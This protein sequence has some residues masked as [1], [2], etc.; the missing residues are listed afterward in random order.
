MSVDN[1]TKHFDG[2]S[3][4]PTPVGLRVPNTVSRSPS[5]GDRS[6]L[7]VI[8][9]S[10]KPILDAELNLGQDIQWMQGHLS[11]RWQSPSGWLGRNNKKDAYFDWI[12][13]QAPDGVTDNSDDTGWDF[14]LEVEDRIHADGTLLDAVVLPKLEALVAGHHVVVEYTNTA[15]PGYN[16]V[17]LDPAKVYDGTNASVKRTDFVFLEVWK[18]LVAPSPLATGYVQVVSVDD[19]TVGDT[20][21]IDGTS[22][23]AVA[24]APGVDEFE[25]GATEEETASNIEA[26]LNDAANSFEGL[27][28]ARA[29][30]N[31]VFLTSAVAGSDGNAVTLALTVSILGCMAVSGATL[32]GGDDRPNKPVTDQSKLFRHGNTLSPSETWLDDQLLD[33]VLATESTQRIQLQYRI[34]ST[35]DSEA[36]NF[37]SNPDGF[38][39]LVSGG[40][41]DEPA[42]FAQG[43][44]DQPVWSGN[45]TDSVSYPFVPAD[46]ESTWLESSAEAFGWLD[47]GLWVAGDGSS[48]A[49]SALG[50]IDGFVYAIPIAFVHRHNN[51]S[52][53]TAS[54]KGFDPASNTN[55][56]P[57]YDHAG[58]TSNLG[59][60]VPA[61]I[62][63]RPD[64]HFCNVIHEDNL[65]DLRRH[66]SLTSVDLASELQTQMQSLLDGNFRTWSVDMA[67]KQTLGGDSG[68]VSTRYL[69]CN[70]IG[71]SEAQGGSSPVSGENTD[72]GVLVR[73]YD[74]VARRF[75]AQPVVERVVVGFWPGDRDGAPVSPG[76]NN[77]GKYVD[78][79]GSSTDTWYEGDTLHLD[80]SELNVTTL[81]GVFDS[82][83]GAGDGG[84][85]SGVGLP[86]STFTAFC[87]EG[88]VITDV[89]N[90]WHDDG[91]YD[92]ATDQEVKFGVI[93]GLGT[94]HLELTLDANDTA[95]TEGQPIGGGNV[96]HKMVG[97][98]VLTDPED[99]G[100]PRRIFVEVEITYPVGSGVTDTV[101]YVLEPDEAVY[102]PDNGVEAGPGPII[103]ND[104]S[105]RPADMENLLAPR[106]RAGYR[107][108]QHEYIANDTIAH[109]APLG[110]SAI[111]TVT[112][113]TLVSVDRNTLR[114]PRR[115]WTDNLGA[116]LYVADAPGVTVMSVDLDNSEFGSSSRLVEL[117]TTV[118]GLLSGVG[119]TLCVV[120][121][122]A[123][124]PIPNYGVNGGGYQ[125]SYYY[126]SNAPQTAG[127]KDG[128]ITTSG[129]G[130][131]PT[132][133]EVEPLIVSSHV[134]TGQVGMGSL[135]KGFPYTA[136]LD[137]LPIH[138]GTTVPSG[139]DE[140]S[141]TTEEW[142]FSATAEVTLGDFDAETGALQLQA[143]V[144]QDAQGLLTLGGSGNDEKPRKDAEFRAYY[145]FADDASYRPT[146]MAQP[147]FGSTRHKVWVPFLARATQDVPGSDGGLLF[148]KSELLLIVLTRFAELDDENTVR[149]VDPVEDNRTAAAVYRTKN[150]LLTVG[151][152]VCPE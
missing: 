53:V 76:T 2:I 105:Q 147:L 64:G 66:V 60:A 47:D 19:I 83:D 102:D 15:T 132:T 122:F 120:K 4:S 79:A 116:G 37:K 124:D 129:G 3:Q 46:G 145:P 57:E 28:V 1:H 22:L 6:F 97:S 25:I 61:G 131:L 48:T 8:A 118:T 104:S 55:A 26:A 7:G 36:I 27:V 63:D 138:D 18:A 150:L 74:H 106:F 107:E 99:Y 112:Q 56:A 73:S 134:W 90:A 9:E 67:D 75:G 34:R 95:T 146:V 80:L 59:F 30:T 17:T 130:V 141:G 137:Q 127:S 54:T 39:S 135:S 87:P 111:G 103:E 85:G 109:G 143:F 68:D 69:V 78:K 58:F 81:G 31:I 11:R 10:G 96:E 14:G 152:R 101:D 110:G 65:L 125:I 29:L 94:T 113:E 24:G 144:Q 123:Q 140:I 136:P 23:T 62:S 49:A 13:G 115:V 51:A 98:G 52:D 70:E 133:L 71:R 77:A 35:G 91:H 82:R 89:L 45:G 42:V 33:T 108:V 12:L 93:T 5:V 100:S 151:D 16:L 149:F 121:Y 126:R 114:F 86:D 142:F 38:S 32:T 92:Q 41:P 119:H 117:D 50:S 21:D 148:R 40:G 84:G 43:N 20:I 128:D 88:T 139:P 44:R 72:R